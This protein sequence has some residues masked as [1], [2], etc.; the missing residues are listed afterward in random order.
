MNET[1]SLCSDLLSHLRRDS[2]FQ[3]IVLNWYDGP[4]RGVLRCLSC[5]AESLIDVI[6]WE[7][8]DDGDVR[9][10]TV[11]PLPL[12]TLETLA[13]WEP[14]LNPII[15]PIWTP[16]WEFDD[17]DREKAA[18]AV[19]K[20]RLAFAAMPTSL[21]AWRG[22]ANFD[23]IAVGHLERES[24]RLAMQAMTGRRRQGW[25]IDWFAYLGLH[26][27]GEN[28]GDKGKGTGGRERGTGAL[29]DRREP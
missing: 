12:G 11:S 25:P 9:V 22:N 16:V 26:R 2:G 14:K 21:I 15:W 1:Y 5:S 23:F 10:A 3:L 4:M 17:R 19:I 27:K 13:I 29:I 6:D 18:R 7:E 20:D 8:H 24:C 28:E